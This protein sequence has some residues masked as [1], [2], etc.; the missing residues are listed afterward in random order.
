MSDIQ[1]EMK[2]EEK[3]KAIVP[4]KGVDIRGRDIVIGFFGWAIIWNIWFIIFFM[5]LAEWL[6]SYHVTYPYTLILYVSLPL[7]AGV[8]FVRIKKVGIVIGSI[9]AIFTSSILL[10]ALGAPLSLNLLLLPFPLG[11]IFAVGQ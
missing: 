10:I 8:Y 7:I 6:A 2:N 3:D 4:R 9:I 11:V 5:G 1:A